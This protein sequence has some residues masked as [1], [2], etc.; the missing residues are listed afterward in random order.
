MQWLCPR[1]PEG[2]AGEAPVTGTRP[3]CLNLPSA[4]PSPWR[5]RS[6]CP[7][8]D[9]L[10][11][12]HRTKG[13]QAL[14]SPGGLRQGFAPPP[15]APILLPPPSAPRTGHL[16]FLGGASDSALS[17]ALSPH[18]CLRA[19]S[20][21]AGQG[22]RLPPPPGSLGFGLPLCWGYGTSNAA[23]CGSLA[24]YPIELPRPLHPSQFWRVSVSS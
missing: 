5:G 4:S 24:P 23:F 3:S 17:P 10:E 2:R 6:S 19:L 21:L 20:S 12:I 11:L 9:G 7:G 16:I 18:L 14:A 1:Q 22:P 8:N 13:S 15:A